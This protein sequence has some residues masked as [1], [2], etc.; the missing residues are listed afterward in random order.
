MRH[1][2]APPC[3]IAAASAAAFVASAKNVRSFADEKR[4]LRRQRSAR[5]EII[6][7]LAGCDLASLDVGLIE[8]VDVEDRSGNRCGDLPPE[9]L[10]P[11]VVRIVDS[12]ADYR[13]SCAFKCIEGR[14]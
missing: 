14:V 12:N 11:E 8:W 5:F 4:R 7:Q 9:K 13:L 3:P 10:L 2:R 1:A 6:R